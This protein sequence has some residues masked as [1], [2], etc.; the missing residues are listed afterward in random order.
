M[1]A[2]ELEEVGAETS[3]GKG[4]IIIL[5][6]VGL[7]LV[8]LAIAGTLYFLGTFS[9]DEEASEEHQEGATAEAQAATKAP[10]VYYPIQ[11]SIVVAFNSR[12][13]QRFLQVDI[14]VMS[15]D[16]LSLEAVQLHAPMIRNNLTLLFGSQDYDGLRVKEGREFV[17]LKVIEEIQSIMQQEIGKPGIENAYFTNFVMQ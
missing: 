1:A 9:K 4:K 11:P 10:A 15:R 8:A 17:R 13:R 5:A 16:P 7:I 12:G 14:T 2:E 3:G 6:S